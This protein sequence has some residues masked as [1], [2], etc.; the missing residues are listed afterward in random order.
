MELERDGAGLL[1]ASLPPQFPFTVQ[2]RNG[3]RC[4]VASREL[5]PGEVVLTGILL[6]LVMSSIILS[7]QISKQYLCQN[8]NVI[9][10]ALLLGPASSSVCWVCCS[11]PG[12]S[13]APCPACPARLCGGCRVGGA[14][15]RQECTALARVSNTP[16]GFNLVMPVRLALL[17]INDPDMFEWIM[18]LMDHCQARLQKINTSLHWFQTLLKTI[19]TNILKYYVVMWSP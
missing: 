18:Q 17:Q 11:A 3:G 14:H 9:D 10:S 15:G 12:P 7:I 13:P 8:T 19:K 16:G 1:T 2:T 6:Y 4:L 5:R